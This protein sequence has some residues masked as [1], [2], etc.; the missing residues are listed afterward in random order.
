MMIYANIRKS[1]VKLKPKKER[2]EY[3][4]WLDKHQVGVKTKSKTNAKLEYS[5]AAPAGRETKTV[6]PSRN[7]GPGDATLKPRNIY[8]GDKMLGIGTLHK[9]NAVPI[10]STEEAHSIAQMRR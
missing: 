4:S 1:K 2:D 8:T 6:F 10:F 9:S 7:T 3:Q 5:L